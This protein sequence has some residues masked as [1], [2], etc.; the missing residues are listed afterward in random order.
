MKPLFSAC[1]ISMLFAVGCSGFG[2]ARDASSQESQLNLQDTGCPA[3]GLPE[4]G[5]DCTEEGAF[6]GGSICTNPCQFCNVVSCTGGVWQ[7]LEAHP[8][9]PEVPFEMNDGNCMVGCICTGEYGDEL[10]CSGDCVGQASCS[11]L[12][13]QECREALDCVPYGISWCLG[14]FEFLEC[15]EAPTHPCDTG[16]RLLCDVYAV[17]PCSEG[18]IPIVRDCEPLCVDPETCEEP[19]PGADCY[20]QMTVSSCSAHPG[21]EWLM[22]EPW[23]CGV[24]ILPVPGCFPTIDCVTNT[25]CP[26][27]SSCEYVAFGA[28]DQPGDLCDACASY[29]KLCITDDGVCNSNEDCPEG[30]LCVQDCDDWCDQ[31]S[32]PNDCCERYCAPILPAACE[33]AGG[34]CTGEPC[35]GSYTTNIPPEDP[36]LWNCAGG[37]TCC[38]PNIS[39]C[40]EVATWWLCEGYPQ[41]QWQQSDCSPGLC[42]TPNEGICDNRSGQISDACFSNEGCE[43]NLVCC[44]PCGIAGCLNR[45][46]EPC[47][48]DMCWNGC[49]MGIP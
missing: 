43:D 19:D 32:F 29:R 1:A 30:Q 26:T 2:D 13:E 41:C 11:D 16:E 39:D 3:E 24:A 10:V 36:E 46:M 31:N 49:P 33:P 9:S 38:L 48:G 8:M 15:R 18:L 5:T 45:C 42:S 7:M 37:Q 40:S 6:C 21:C 23:A 12:D 4:I 20:N 44:Y 34:V 25:D 14:C 35:E 47:Y 27:S 17:L 28:C 22:P